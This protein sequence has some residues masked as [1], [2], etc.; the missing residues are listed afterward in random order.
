MPPLD[1]D[2]RI[3][4]HV[5]FTPTPGRDLAEECREVRDLLEINISRSSRSAGRMPSVAH[6]LSGDTRE[7]WTGD[8]F[9]R[10]PGAA[11]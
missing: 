1:Y 8:S 4:G 3:L 10:I 5:I 6:E 7:S 2:S 9:P 11:A